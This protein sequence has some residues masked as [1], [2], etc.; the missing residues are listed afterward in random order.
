MVSISFA[1]PK[2]PSEVVDTLASIDGPLDVYCWYEGK[3]GLPQ[4]GAKFMRDA[5]LEPLYEKKRDASLHLYSLKAWNFQGGSGLRI[6]RTHVAFIESSSFF[7]YCREE[8]RLYPFIQ[9]E[10]P[11][12]KR[13]IR[14]SET[15]KSC[16]KKVGE[17]FKNSLLDCLQTWDL[18][19][20]YACMQYLEGYYLIR[21]AFLRGNKTVAF[22]LPNDENK[23]YYDFETDLKTM[24]E[25]DFG[26]GVELT[27]LFQ[28][29]QYGTDSSSRP[30]NA[31][32]KRVKPA[33]L[34][35]Y[36]DYMRKPFLREV[37]HNL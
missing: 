14:L 18:S 22:M 9:E 36:F 16:G 19:Q 26:I 34:G 13:L 2:A 7:K 12:K 3:N 11:T 8:K 32:G 15:F 4:E 25:L 28:A 35:I 30:Y 24:L 33:E 10:L 5:L 6:E 29:F 23:Y 1:G 17:L 21:E 20:A 37:I 31:S 27:V